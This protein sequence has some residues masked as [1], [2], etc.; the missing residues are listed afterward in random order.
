MKVLFSLAK[1]KIHNNKLKIGKEK[2]EISEILNYKPY[3]EKKQKIKTK[4]VNHKLN[5]NNH[6]L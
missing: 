3:I 4:I 1:K 5:T 6:K 2:N